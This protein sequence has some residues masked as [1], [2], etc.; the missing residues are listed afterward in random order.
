MA[1][2]AA[3]RRLRA[4]GVES[5]ILEKSRGPG[6][7]CATRRQDGFIWDT[8]ATSLLPRGRTLG[9]VI[10]NELP[11]DDLV[12][13]KKAVSL[14]DNFRISAG[15]P[16][17]GGQRWAY[18][19]GMNRLAHLLAEGLDI[20]PKSNVDRIERSAVGY[21]IL[22]ES[23]D[24]VVITVPTPQASLLLWS[25]DER[26]PV[27]NVRYR[28]CL[29]V[30]LGYDIPLPET[31]YFA[32]LDATQ[33][34]P[35]VWLSLESVKC[36]TRAP[37]VVVQF[38]REYSRRWYMRPEEEMVVTAAQYMVALYGPAYAKPVASDLM[39]WKYAQPEALAP[40]EEVNPPGS[41]LILAGD[42]L[43]GGHLEEAFECGWNAAEMLLA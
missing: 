25:I 3:G 1:G 41:R 27:A 2:L 11:T 8:G 4:A 10:Q 19:S 20:R 33:R 22:G 40:F 6:G 12:E 21:E 34:H 23:Y 7:R 24:R 29:S 30:G 43:Y 14:H 35:M 17:R 13:V 36:P 37:A 26:R 9:N 16:T 38:N 31:P 15:D 18:G 42:A 39:R 5:V 32:L 28:P